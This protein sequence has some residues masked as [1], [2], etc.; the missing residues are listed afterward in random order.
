MYPESDLNKR[1]L[2]VFR[3]R[4]LADSTASVGSLSTTESPRGLPIAASFPPAREK[5]R[6]RCDRDS[7]LSENRVRSVPFG[8]PQPPMCP[9]SGTETTPAFVS[10]QVATARRFYLNLR[11]RREA[12]IAVVC[13]GCESCAPDYMIDRVT[14]PYLSIEFVAAGAGTLELAGE[15]YPLQPGSVFAYGPKAGHQIRTDP[16]KPLLKYF[17]DFIGGAAVALMRDTG[18]APGAFRPVTEISDVRDSFDTLIRV[19]S[20]RDA[21]TEQMCGLQLQLLLYT[22]ARSPEAASAN[23]RR[24]RL[25]FERCRQFIDAEF[26]RF[27]SID[28]VAE[29]CH[30][31]RSHLCR[32]FRRFHDESPLRYLQRLRMHWAANRLQE[33]PLLV[34]Q[35]ALELKTDPYHFCRVFK[36]VHGVAPTEF[37]T[38]R[39]ASP[40]R[41]AE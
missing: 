15:S 13:G 19:G 24:A 40:S 33:S 41:S 39:A 20:K 25:R 34:R 7:T 36:R 32:L 30:I 9:D 27:D 6:P 2:G 11:P 3:W 16:R 38:S 35:I 23:E 12:G 10:R 28:D 1:F 4:F 37:L 18:L 21:Y 31:D 26:L 29:A 5:L 22:I 8:N 14:F 17:V